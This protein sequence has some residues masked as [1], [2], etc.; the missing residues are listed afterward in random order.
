MVRRQWAKV[1]DHILARY[2]LPPAN[3]AFINWET[4]AN[5]I[6]LTVI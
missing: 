6:A 5:F 2:P 3:D 4:S 1:A